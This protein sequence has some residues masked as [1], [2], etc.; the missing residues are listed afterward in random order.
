MVLSI[1]TT[2]IHDDDQQQTIE[3]V[4]NEREYDIENRDTLLLAGAGKQSNLQRA[5]ASAGTEPAQ[6]QRHHVEQ[7]SE[8]VLP[9]V[10]SLASRIEQKKGHP[11]PKPAGSFT[12]RA[13]SGP[14]QVSPGK[15]SQKGGTPAAGIGKEPPQERHKRVLTTLEVKQAPPQRPQV[16]LCK[17]LNV[18]IF[19]HVHTKRHLVFKSWLSRTTYLR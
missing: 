16:R 2:S 4:S 13:A 15:L 3:N 6:G 17:T 5:N 11:A 19:S 8:A 14:P 10:K 7:T 18:N 9:S 1:K 12:I